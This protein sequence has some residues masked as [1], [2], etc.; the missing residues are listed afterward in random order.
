MRLL[1]GPLAALL[2]EEPRERLALRHG[3]DAAAWSA[4]VGVLEL[5]GAGLA[6]VGDFVTQIP[7]LVD[8]HTAAFL[9]NT[10]DPML[11]DSANAQALTLSGFWSWLV[12]LSQP[13]VLLLFLVTLTGIVRLTAF[14]VTREAVSEPLVW[15]GWHAWR[16][17]VRQPAAAAREQADYGPAKRPDRVLP[18]PDGGL[19]VL[20]SR[21]RPEWNELVTIQV[22]ERFF[23]VEDVHERQEGP[24]R[25][26]AY[27]L[28]EE[29]PGVVIRALLLYEPPLSSET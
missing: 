29:H 27:R 18:Q 4:L 25:W 14:A 26:H 8:D 16:V 23:R 6:L 28:R 12:W 11:R 3:V 24:W 2:P 19:L 9:E 5:F 1:A 21:L 20:T 10:P 17:L 13:T 22:G 15:L 7:R